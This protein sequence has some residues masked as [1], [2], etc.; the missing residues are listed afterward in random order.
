MIDTIWQNESTLC[1]QIVYHFS[2]IEIILPSFVNNLESRHS[3]RP[4]DYFCDICVCLF[5]HIANNK[6]EACYSQRIRKLFCFFFFFF[7][8]NVSL[9]K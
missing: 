1:L 6:V 2:F 8:M 5:I 3:F 4:Y 7:S 9:D